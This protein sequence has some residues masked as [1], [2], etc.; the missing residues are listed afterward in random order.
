MGG[1]SCYMHINS[2]VPLVTKPAKDHAS[3]SPGRNFC[4]F[5]SHTKR[6]GMHAECQFLLSM[7]SSP[8]IWVVGIRWATY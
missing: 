8:V 7:T 2:E 3:E 1:V 4:S 6:H 5:H